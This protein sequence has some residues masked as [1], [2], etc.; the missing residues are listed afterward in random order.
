MKNK[1]LF[2]II[3]YLGIA[4]SFLILDVGLRYFVTKK[5]GFVSVKSYSPLAFSVSYIL[6]L[7]VIMNLFKKRAK[8]IYIILTILA[9]IYF[10]AQMMHFKI[11]GNTFSLI[12][13]FSAG[14]ATDYLDYILKAT[15]NEILIVILLSFLS[16]IT[17]F[18]ILK[19]T[20]TKLFDEKPTKKC[21]LILALIFIFLRVSAIYKL[22][23]SVDDYNWDAWKVPKNVYNNYSNNDRAMLVSGVYEY[24]FRDAYLYFKRLVFTNNKKEIKAVDE[25]MASADNELTTNEYTGIFKDK[26]LIII[27]LESIDN[28][29]VTPDIMPTMYQLSQE[30]LNFTN[31]YAPFYG[32]G[33]TI[34][35]EF[36]GISGLYSL[37][38]DKA[39]YNYNKNDFSY[40][41]PS[42]FRDNGYTANSIHMN[43]GDFYNRKNFHE[44]LGFERHY[45]L[46]QMGFNDD[47]IYD[48]TIVK[49]DK[50]YNL[51]VSENKFVTFITT[52]SAHVPYAD[53][54]ICK[55]KDGKNKALEV[56][57][58][59]ELSCLNILA[60]ETDAFIKLLIERLDKDGY[61]DNTVIVLYADHFAYGYTKVN[62]QKGIEDNNLI[63]K[64]P[65][66]IWS[67]NLKHQD[68]D[69]IMD[70]A[71]IPVTLFNM[72]SITYEPKL[73]MGTDVFS[74]NH[75]KFV[76]FKDYSWYDGSYYSIDNKEDEYTKNISKIVN[77]KIDINTKLL[78]SNYYK[79]YKKAN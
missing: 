12:S 44:G 77:Q 29:L 72:F 8:L 19:A 23:K 57:D 22:G 27:M 40:S 35:S 6:V 50:S 25:Y 45:P 18:C 54:E 53:N 3:C 15:T 4:F 16:V 67:K 9:N 70:T 73:Y 30:G 17:V 28:W 2:K 33:M 21:L 36:A 51:I 63:Q 11:L 74:N 60:N 26:N 24:V 58:N 14:E 38:T 32:S 49:N 65:F 52:Y 5:I 64:T 78:H 56:K 20:K 68:V 13:V 43:D 31:R 10:F 39:I 47:F 59:P 55:A 34:N 71:D 46:Y 76:Y 79:Y 75:E 62:E 41:L 42:L 7:L 66:I 48:T 61:L 69:T 37:T 1:R